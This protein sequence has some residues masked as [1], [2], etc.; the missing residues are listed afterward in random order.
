MKDA[1]DTARNVHEGFEPLKDQVDHVATGEA[2]HVQH[3]DHRI[4]GLLRHVE[5]D[6]VSV[7]VISSYSGILSCFFHGF[8]SFFVRSDAKA[9]ATRFRVEC[10]VI[11]SS[12]KP[13][14]AATKGLAKRS[15]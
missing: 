9:R 14:S 6:L 11:T 1:R 13:F 12:M 2:R 8:V 7:H 15:S 10:G 4:G 3:L 5:G